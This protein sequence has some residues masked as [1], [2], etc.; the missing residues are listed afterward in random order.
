MVIVKLAV[1][2]LNNRVPEVAKPVS[3]GYRGVQTW[4]VLYVRASG[5]F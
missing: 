5:K 2:P 3:V 4:E 1:V